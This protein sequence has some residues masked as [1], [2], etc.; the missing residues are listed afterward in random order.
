MD[1]VWVTLASVAHIHAK[2]GTSDLSW[3]GQEELNRY[4]AITASRR[5]NQ[6]LSGR[7]FAR[8]CLASQVGGQW[9]DY[10]LSAP[11][12]APP[13]VLKQPTNAVKKPLHISLSHSSDYL[14]CAVATRP[15]GVDIENTATKRDG[16]AMSSFVLSEDEFSSVLD[17][18]TN[19][20]R[21]QFYARWTLKEAWIKQC[22][23]AT[24]MQAIACF[25]CD[26]PD[27]LGAVI[28]TANWTLAVTPVKPE[29][30]TIEGLL[31]EELV[32]QR[33]QVNGQIINHK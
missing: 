1:H 8:E 7:R 6:F 28:S 9:H 21:A 14:V 3:L 33:W 10:L 15:V 30:L 16:V 17:L 18:P 32:C 31:A 29:N 11:V 19:E 5:R 23:T 2:N 25:P 27:A 4:H 24:A 20:R 26:H 12:N 22:P 13:L